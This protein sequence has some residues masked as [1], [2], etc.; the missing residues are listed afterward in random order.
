MLNTPQQKPNIA[1]FTARS[2]ARVRKKRSSEIFSLFF[3]VCF[4]GRRSV[5]AMSTD[6][7]ATKNAIQKS[8]M[9]LWQALC[10]QMPTDGA[11]AMAKLLLSP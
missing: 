9:K 2:Q 11:I 4:S 1:M 6:A 8:T 7:I 5:E 3:T 10:N